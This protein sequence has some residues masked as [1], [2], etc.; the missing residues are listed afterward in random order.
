MAKRNNYEQVS[1]IMSNERDIRTLLDT[2]HDRD[3][4]EDDVS[5]LMSERTRDRY[6]SAQEATKAPEGASIGGLSGG[7]LGAI[8]GGLTVAGSLLVPGAGLLVAGPLV[9]A[10]AGGA[11]G[12]ATGGL[13]GALVG[14]GIPEHEAKFYEDALKKEGNI[15]VVAHVP[16]EEASEV[17]AI[18]ERYGAHKVKVH[19]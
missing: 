16:K 12:T 2:L 19:H 13:I 6:F 11:I 9:G 17:K 4:G 15:L 8:I 10:L 18:F 3:L 5:V 14:A 1:G 7:L